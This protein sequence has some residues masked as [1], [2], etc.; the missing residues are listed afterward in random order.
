M[1]CKGFWKLSCKFKGDVDAAIDWTITSLELKG[2]E[3]TEL[4]RLAKRKG[5]G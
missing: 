5:R 4:R 2:A 3:I 1:S